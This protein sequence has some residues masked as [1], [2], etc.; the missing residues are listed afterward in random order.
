M[1]FRTLGTSDLQLPVI[2]FGAWAIGGWMWGGTD[3]KASIE[4][5]KASIDAGVTAIDTAP[6]YGMG[7]SEELVAKATE[8]IPRDQLQILT[9][10]GMRWT[11]DKGTYLADA[12]DSKGQPVKIYKFAGKDSIIEEC[13]DSLRRLKTDYIDL[14]Q[15]HW[16]DATTPIEE[17]MEALNRLLEQGK[18]RYAGVCNY[19]EQQLGIALEKTPLISNQVPYSMIVRGIEAKVVPFCRDH[20]LGILAYSPLQR[21]L[22]TG[23]ITTDYVYSEGDHRDGNK[24][25][26]HDYITRTNAMLAKIKPIADQHQAS[27]AQIVLAWTLEQPGITIALVGART[28]EQARQNAQAAAITLTPEE[29]QTISAEL[30]QSGL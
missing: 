30:Q 2:T 8:G 24:Y 20:Q 5:I 6:I 26:S 9:K 28:A 4:A 15:I 16:Y 7:Y 29:V 27:L 13:N 3:E 23:K 21:G 22:L 14:Y 10:C 19:D 12:V 1:K 17:S 25:F 18:I 11:G